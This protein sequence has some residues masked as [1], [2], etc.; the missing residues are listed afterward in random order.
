[1]RRARGR[2][3]PNLTPK[4]GSLAPCRRYV[5]RVCSV[6]FS[7]SA[8]MA[9]SNDIAIGS[10]PRAC[11]SWC[12]PDSTRGSG[13]LP[14]ASWRASQ[15]G[16]RDRPTLAAMDTPRPDQ[17]GLAYLLAARAGDDKVMEQLRA[18]RGTSPSTSWPWPRTAGL[19]GWRSGSISITAWSSVSPSRGSIRG[20]HGRRSGGNAWLSSRGT[21]CRST[22]SSRASCG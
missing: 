18:R 8:A 1:M 4:S 16:A 15:R 9:A 6:P 21:R 5:L 12:A 7:A 13:L 2:K 11:V 20:C 17:L 14:P 22:R 10:V 3:S 19:A